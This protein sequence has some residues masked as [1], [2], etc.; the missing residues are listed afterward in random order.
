MVI[1]KPKPNY[2]KT[3]AAIILV[4]AIVFAAAYAT[5]SVGERGAGEAAKNVEISLN[6][7]VARCYA[8]EGAYPPDLDYIAEKYGVNPDP[9]RYIVHYEYFG[10]N[11]LPAITVIP[12]D[13]ERSQA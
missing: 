12:A 5:T 13:P 8:A 4:A 2:F 6:R 9:E 3:I 7:A 1:F 10:A 11:L